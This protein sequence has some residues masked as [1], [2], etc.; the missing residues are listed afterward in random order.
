MDVDG[1]GE[2]HYYLAKSCRLI[3]QSYKNLQD[4]IAILGIDE[5]SEDD[6][7]TVAR[8]RKVQKFLS[9]PFVVAEAFTGMEGKNCTIEQTLDGFEAIVEG[10]A[11]HLPEQAFYMTGSLEDVQ[12]T[13]EKMII[14]QKQAEEIAKRAKEAEEAAAAKAESGGDD[15]GEAVEGA[16]VMETDQ[17]LLMVED[18]FVNPADVPEWGHFKKDLTYNA[19]NQDALK[20]AGADP[21]EDLK[22]KFF[23]REQWWGGQDPV[24]K[25]HIHKL[26]A[27][28][29]KAKQ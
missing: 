19:F 22:R 14:Q 13:G 28:R 12:K 21:Q 8:A 11:D 7:I 25:A 20:D 26:N 2:R 9:Q 24:W 16:L 15:D 4:I 17:E 27:A 1:V 3:L 29:G 23:R 6:Q 10:R 5:L 18:Q